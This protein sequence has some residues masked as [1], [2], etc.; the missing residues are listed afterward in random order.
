M[1]FPQCLGIKYNNSEYDFGIEFIDIWAA[2]FH[3][4][5][6][7]CVFETFDVQ[8]IEF[9]MES[10]AYLEETIYLASLFHEVGH[11]V[12]PWK[13]SP[14]S[15]KRL[16]HN[17]F[18]LNVCGELSTDSLMGY[19]IPESWELSV[20]ILIHRLFWFGRFNFNKNKLSGALNNDGDCWIAAYLWNKCLK[21]GVI[22]SREKYH[23]QHERMQE[24]FADIIQEI[25]FLAQSLI[26]CDNQS[27]ELIRWMSSHVPY[28]NDRFIYPPLLREI[29]EK[30]N[31][32]PYKPLPVFHSSF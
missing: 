14:H 30:C 15:D 23:I 21:L 17:Q 3:Q 12:G 20:F 32:F 1:F 19:L 24:L 5:I 25:D 22:E 29:Y 7:T 28:I 6:F 26:D 11:R 9:F 4:I 27:E 10:L 16:N 18:K 2:I 8:S 13:I 31:H